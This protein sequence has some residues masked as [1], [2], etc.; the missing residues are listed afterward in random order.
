MPP[1]VRIMHSGP[2]V[3]MATVSPSSLV[4]G[5]VPPT[6]VV[7]AVASVKPV[8]NVTVASLVK[9]VTPSSVAL[10]AV[11]VPV[12]LTGLLTDISVVTLGDAVV[13]QLL[14][15]I[16]YGVIITWLMFTKT[17]KTVRRIVGCLLWVQLEHNPFILKMSSANCWLFW[18]GLKPEFW[19]I[20]PMPWLLLPWLLVLPWYQQ[21]W[22]LLHMKNR[23]VSSVRTYFSSTCAILLV[24]KVRKCDCIPDS[25][26]HAAYMCP[27]WVLSAP[28]GPHI[29]PMNFVIRDFY[30][31]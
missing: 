13:V 23:Y 10:V 18:Y 17:T 4:V 6:L 31:Y 9:P 7:S 8:G 12:V 19:I 21:P 11:S 26:V 27:T 22:H 15:E 28:G 20:R 25:K 1:V 2:G 29:G 30:V 24:R 16:E 3:V 5:R 14:A